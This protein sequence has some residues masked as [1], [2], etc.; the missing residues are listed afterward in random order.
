[1]K[2]FSQLPKNTGVAAAGGSPGRGVVETGV[3]LKGH[4]EAR[5]DGKS[6]G[7]GGTPGAL[8]GAVLSTRYNFWFFYQLHRCHFRTIN[9][10]K[11]V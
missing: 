2:P 10:L 4:G 9:C 7:S 11:A 8:P 6:A 5:G 3:W 1:M